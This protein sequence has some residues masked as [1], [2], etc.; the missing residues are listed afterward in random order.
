MARGI[1]DKLV[2]RHPH[3]FGADSDYAHLADVGDSD[4]ELLTRNWATIKAQEKGRTSALDGIPPTLPALTWAQKSWRRAGESSLAVTAPPPA[5]VS[6]AGELGDR[7]LALVL[8]A[9]AQGW[10]AESALRDRV[11][12][13]HDD[14]RIAEAQ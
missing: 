8:T 5:D 11:R 3:V 9:E 6:D 14:V 1:I 10:D 2:R 12:R 4:E 7:L 13:L